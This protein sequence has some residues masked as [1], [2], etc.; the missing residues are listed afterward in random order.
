M[1]CCYQI[2]LFSTQF[3]SSF[4][5]SIYLIEITHGISFL[6][7]TFGDKIRDLMSSSGQ[8]LSCINIAGKKGIHCLFGVIFK[9]NSLEVKKSV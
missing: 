3:C 8:F 1:A 4:L 5:F 7:C 2:F 9:E 6:K